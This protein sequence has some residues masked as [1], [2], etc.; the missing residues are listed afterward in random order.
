MGFISY[1]ALLPYNMVWSFLLFVLCDVPMALSI[2]IHFLIKGL[3][4]LTSLHLW[5]FMDGIWRLLKCC[6]LT[7][8]IQTD[9]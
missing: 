3:T 2:L 8:V 1:T 5:L 7:D 4:V 9:T 6:R